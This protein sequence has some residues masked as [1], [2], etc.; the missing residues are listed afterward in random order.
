MNDTQFR[1]LLDHLGLSWQEYRKVRKGVIRRLT[2]HMRELGIR[3]VDNYLARIKSSQDIRM[4]TRRL[5]TVSISRFFRDRPLWEIIHG[6]LLPE[7]MSRRPERVIVWSAGC[8]LGQEVYSFK[9]LWHLLGDAKCPLPPLSVIATDMNQEYLDL[10][11]SGIYDEHAIKGVPEDCLERFF[12]YD[13]GRYKITEALKQDISW[14]LHDLMDASPMNGPFQM[15][16][17]RNNLFTYYKEEFH[18]GPLRRLTETLTPGGYLIIGAREHLP[19]ADLKLVIIDG[20]AGIFQ[21]R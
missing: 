1:R 3:D 17:L 7:I 4:E 21:K 6:K 15:I 14:H 2:R 20:Y 11:V 8:A 10:A 13:Q 9:M 16:F 19:F 5:L 18:E 12:R